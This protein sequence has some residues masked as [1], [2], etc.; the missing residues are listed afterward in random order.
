M[1]MRLERPRTKLGELF[2]PRKVSSRWKSS[3]MYELP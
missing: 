2:I 1:G 3:L